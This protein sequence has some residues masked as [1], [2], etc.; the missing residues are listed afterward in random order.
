MSP[1]SVLDVAGRRGSRLSVALGQVRLRSNTLEPS[2]SRA[3]PTVPAAPRSNGCSI[4]YSRRPL[5]GAVSLERQESSL[6]FLTGGKAPSGHLTTSSYVKN[7]SSIST[8]G[9]ENGRLEHVPGSGIGDPMMS[10]CGCIPPWSLPDFSILNRFRLRVGYL[11]SNSS[12]YC[13]HLVLG[14][15]TGYVPKCTPTAKRGEPR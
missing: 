4:S 15:P 9:S 12:Q 14:F 11:S 3:A 10:L 13:A 2:R 6:K 8:C 7:V 1:Q 5:L